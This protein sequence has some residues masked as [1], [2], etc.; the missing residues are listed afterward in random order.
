MKKE[1]ERYLSHWPSTILRDRDLY[2]HFESF[3]DQA[4]RDLIHRAIEWEWIEKIK[5]GLYLIKAP[6]QRELPSRFEMAQ[7]I[8][9]PSYISM[10]SAFSYYQ[11]IPEAVRVTVSVCP[12][13]KTEF[14]TPQG[15]FLFHRIPITNFYE[16][17]RRVKEGKSVFLIAT[18]LKA[19][20][21]YIY[22]SR[23]RYSRAIDIA[24]DLRIE[25]DTL[26]KQPKKLLKTLSKKYPSKRVQQ[27]YRELGE[28][29]F[30][31]H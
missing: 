29:L 1:L 20:G 6:F 17:V 2:W 14:F 11:M 18:P 28:D 30:N 9:G 26:A 31:D 21:D 12:K 4:K 19:I 7:Y 13:R 5:R 3:P 22:V 25:Y 10:E 24:D 27:F 16:G 15:V 8:Y 23:K